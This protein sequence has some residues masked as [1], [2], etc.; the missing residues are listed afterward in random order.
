VLAFTGSNFLKIHVSGN[1]NFKTPLVGEWFIQWICLRESLNRKT[2]D[3]CHQI[4][5]ISCKRSL[6]PIHLLFPK[7]R[8]DKN[9][10]TWNI[11]EQ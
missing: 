3:V 9:L 8:G 2:M 4:S 5:G 7:I 1:F 11:G 10:I 6:K